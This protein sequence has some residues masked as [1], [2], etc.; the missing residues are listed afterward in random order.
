MI[1]YWQTICMKKQTFLNGV[2]ILL[3]GSIIAK[4]LG[5]F[6]RIPLTWILGAEGLGI[7][8]LVFPIFSLILVVSSTGMPTAISKMIAE[9]KDNIKEANKILKVSLITLLIIGTFFGLVLFFGAGLISN[10]QGNSLAK[11][12][13]IAIAPSVAFV[14]VISAFRGYFQGRMNMTPTSMSNIIEQFF[15]LIFG[16]SLAFL[17]LPQGLQFGVLGAILGV[18]LSEVVAMIYMLIVFA[19]EKKKE[20]NIIQQNVAVS[21]TK[22]ILKLLFKT[23]MPIVFVSIII[24]LSL[25]V[26]SFLVV[27]LLNLSGQSVQQSTILWGI[28]SGI[29]TSIVNLPVVLTLAVATAVV[30]SLVSDLQ[31]RKE[32]I[33]QSMLI[34]QNISMPCAFGVLVLS[35]LIL[36]FLYGGSFS[37]TIIDEFG[38][39]SSLLSASSFLIFFT[40]VLQTQNASLQG[41]GHLK[42]PAV[43]MT[44]AVV[45]KTVMLLLTTIPSVNVFGVM[46]AKYAFFFVATM[47][48]AVFLY[49]KGY[50]LSKKAEMLTTF[51]SSLTMALG[52][53][54]INN[55]NFN[56]SVYLLLP[57]EIFVGILIF[58]GSYICLSPNKTYFK[59]EKS[60]NKSL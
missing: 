30:P 37:N 28:E 9:K 19:I 14:A 34:S 1:F 59:F 24:P 22:D 36:K 33:K 42:V 31:K 2:L 46:I 7:Y 47:L 13:Y 39:A 15:K 32:R 25:F 10:L 54:V 57:I 44:I 5:A 16:L 11:L 29:V 49:K 23:A 40:S 27:N 56:L 21:K 20:K 43:N 4:G 8:Q 53:L 6:Y 48:N 18:T 17:F 45:I 38:T 51:V 3:F 50:M 41:L 55:F 26:D 12:S 35:P 60:K 58:A 52:L